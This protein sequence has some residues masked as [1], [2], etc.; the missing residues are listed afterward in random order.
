MTTRQQ[1]NVHLSNKPKLEQI[2]NHHFSQG[3]SRMSMTHI[4]EELIDHEFKRL[5]LCA[6]EATSPS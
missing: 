1:I 4:I 3:R 5:Q 6:T 2:R